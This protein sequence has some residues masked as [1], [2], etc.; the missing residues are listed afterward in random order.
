MKKFIISLIKYIIIPNILMLTTIYLFDVFQLRDFQDYYLD[1]T[2]DKNRS[3]ITANT[4]LN[5]RKNEKFN[6]F[7]FGSSR[8]HAFKCK[9]WDNYLA[10]DSK[11]F[12]FDGSG[13]GLWNIHKKVKFLDELG[14]SIKNALIIIDHN[15]LKNTKPRYEHIYIEHPRISKGSWIIFY[16]QFIKINYNW[17]FFVPI[18]DYKIFKV[19]R[20][21]MR[22]S[23]NNK[24]YND[25]SNNINCDIWYGEDEHLRNDSLGY[26]DAYLL[27][28][29]Y[30]RSKKQKYASSIITNDEII[31]LNEIR[32]IFDKHKTT[33]KIVISP[34]YDQLQIGKKQEGLIRNIFGTKNVYN[35]SGINRFTTF[36]QN[37]YENSHYKPLVANKIMK[38]IYYK[39]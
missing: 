12:H 17:K 2:V 14:D 10:T 3:F 39:N 13:E 5:N 9:N 26:Y 32:N 34:L 8:S 11:S 35:F 33:Y 16:Y 7:I 29:F 36:I 1:Q 15:T 23:I 21:Y 19:Y 27:S 38:T 4:Y 22:G 28:T 24:K 25:I 37:Y 30:E 18:I 20:N 6:S 31:Q